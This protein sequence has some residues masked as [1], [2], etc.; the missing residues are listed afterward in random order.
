MINWRTDNARSVCTAAVR[1]TYAAPAVSVSRERA[2]S[3]QNNRIML[4]SPII[5]R[6]SALYVV[7]VVV[8]SVGMTVCVSV[9]YSVAELLQCAQNRNM[10]SWRINAGHGNTHKTQKNSMF[11][12]VT[13]N[14]E[15]CV[16]YTSFHKMIG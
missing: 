3:A 2:P 5:L 13:R 7:V 11:F 10:T 8:V 9:L 16:R 6:S 1:C 12:L 14:G 4:T 15:H